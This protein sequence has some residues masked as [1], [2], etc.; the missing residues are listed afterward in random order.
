MGWEDWTER[1]C[2]TQCA[3]SSSERAERHDAADGNSTKPNPSQQR[4]R[5]ASDRTGNQRVANDE[6]AAAA[7]GQNAPAVR[8]EVEDHR[9]D[10]PGE[11]TDEKPTRG[12]C[13]GRSKGTA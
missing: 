12:Q 1:E 6:G 2:C 8:G 13:G 9:G 10:R 5:D 11:C 4:G 3:D 7:S